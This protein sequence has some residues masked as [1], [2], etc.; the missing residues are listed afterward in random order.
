[1]SLLPARVAQADAE[2]PERDGVRVTELRKSFGERAVLR[3]VSIVVPEGSITA[4]LGPSGSGKTTLLRLVAGF[5]RPDSGTIVIG[6]QVVDD[7]VGFVRPQQRGV[8]Y[9]PQEGSLFPHL[10]VVD[11]IGFGVARGERQRVVPPL[12]E[13][14]GLNG[15]ER[16]YPHQLSGGE[17]QRVALARALAI[18]PKIVLLD[19]PFASLDP[20]LRQGVRRDVLRILNET[21]STAILVTHDQEEALALADQ[22][23]VLRHGGV[24]AAGDPRTLYRSP[25]DPAAAVSLGDVNVLVAD[26][27][28]GRARSP[29]GEID[30]VSISGR[31]VEGAAR[32]L[33]RPEQLTLHSEP[34]PG[35]VHAVV[36]ENQ[37]YGHDAVVLLAL[38]APG[39]SPLSARV[40]GELSF[41]SGDG[42]WVGAHGPGLVW[43]RDEVRDRD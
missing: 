16:R 15:L 35:A 40:S 29:L 12:V 27:H 3:D 39:T 9:V 4:V 23:V 43:Q 7:G 34:V 31:P 25:P 17:Q 13:L 19:E 21:G 26:V 6:G 42:I 24:V 32:L 18:G 8:G 22:V 33:L 10:T 37:Y 28:D 14:V 5:D 30:A 1:V 11:N 2:R 38:D 20:A 36:I 41:A